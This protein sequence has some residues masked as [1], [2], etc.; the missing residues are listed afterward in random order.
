MEGASELKGPDLENIKTQLV[1]H[2]LASAWLEGGP[3]AID[4]LEDQKLEGE[5]YH[6]F[7]LTGAEGIKFYVDRESHLLSAILLPI[8]DP[9]LGDTIILVRLDDYKAYE[10]IMLPDTQ[11]VDVAAG[12][13]TI[14][15]KYTE[16]SINPELDAALFEKP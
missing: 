7:Q 16:T 5:T 1:I 11:E 12:T 13:I 15:Y 9:A 2:P 3:N 14:E 10:G 6:V 8:S 4:A